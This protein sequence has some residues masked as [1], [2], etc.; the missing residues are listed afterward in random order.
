MLTNFI[1]RRQDGI[2]PFAAAV[3]AAAG[4]ILTGCNKTDQ[5]ADAGPAGPEGEPA[6]VVEAAGSAT[7]PDSV[8]VEVD[9]AELTS[10]QLQKKLAS[11]MASPRMQDVPEEKMGDLRGMLKQRLVNAFVAETVLINE[12]KEQGVTADEAD[13]EE[14]MDKIK[15]KLPE[16]VELSQALAG[17]GMTE[18]GL[19]TDVS[20]E[21]TIN[22][23]LEMQTAT[24]PGITDE[25]IEDFY[26]EN[27]SYFEEPETVHARHILITCDTDAD[28]E[29]HATAKA[30]AE[31]IRE[32]LVEG[33]DFAELAKE[34]SD[35]PSKEEGGDLGTFGRGKMVTEFEEAAFSQDEGQIGPVI[36]T[37]FGYHIV[38][39]LE[40]NEEGTQSLEEA[41]DRI[42]Q[43]LEKEQKQEA[44][45]SYIEGLKDE[46]T[47][48]YG[49]SQTS[50]TSSE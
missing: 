12:A 6:P 8:V 24:L 30:K 2:L 26:E 36:K 29:Q 25:A 23:L 3:I 44:V 32:E 15:A 19:R 50:G 10:G 46:A 7:A 9:G 17:Y 21:M 39:V 22:K 5:A 33:A 31:A 13:V 41:S 27:A 40:H 4:F 45:A 14:A 48:T 35:C 18:Q 11:M 38:E 49:E 43:H 47:I 42:T 20:R 16:G 34:H 1:V 28:E 37:K